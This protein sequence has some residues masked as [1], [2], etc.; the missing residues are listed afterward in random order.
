MRGV[1]ERKMGARGTS[2]MAHCSSTGGGMGS[3]PGWGTKIPHAP[4]PGQKVKTNKQNG[5]EP[6][7]MNLKGMG[8][9]FVL[10]LLWS[11]SD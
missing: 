6:D 7:S 2:L 9:A 4:R 5:R 10:D 1:I 11:R 3:D 8:F